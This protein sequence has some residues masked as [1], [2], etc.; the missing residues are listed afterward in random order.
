MQN[1]F[2]TVI[3]LLILLS[4]GL[5]AGNRKGQELSQK[6]ISRD[7]RLNSGAYHQIRGGLANSYLKFTRQKKGRVVFLGGSI[8]YGAGWRDDVCK[9]LQE[10]FPETKF[11]FINAGIGSTGST[12]GAFRMQ[13]DVLSFG[14]VDL[15]FEDASVNDR[16]N[17][18]DTAACVRG[19]EG[20]VHRALK[21]NPL[22]DIV[23][24]YFVDPSKIKDYNN[25]ITP[26]EIT[27]HNNVAVHYNLPSVNLAK[28]VTDRINNKE[29]TW[30]NDFL[31]LHP[32][33]FGHELY[34]N[35]IRSF[36]ETCWTQ[37][38]GKQKRE[39]HKIPSLLN[40]YSYIKA[41]Y[42]GIKG[43]VPDANWSFEQ[44]WT[45]DNS[46]VI[47]PMC[48][49]ISIVS[50][51]K[52]G[53]VIEFSFIG[54]AVGICAVTGPDAGMVEYTIDGKYK[55]EVDLY[56]PWSHGYNIPWFVVFKHDL[57]PS[58]HLLQVRVIDKRNPK[59]EGNAC[60]IIHFLVNK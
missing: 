26:V 39:P 4:Y 23:L 47:H 40:R 13:K 42:A 36:L 5:F 1:F 10:R 41:D 8:T 11:E 56:T 35:S 37:A 3:P 22:T 32:S 28:E 53:A 16:V 51:E 49:N 31:D 7:E 25:G 52:P 2:K 46:L 54:K 48:R 60:R 55:G 38:S 30:E 18:F 12:P 6:E 14:E 29:F 50:S 33:P 44:N 59:S 15:L 20:I 21:A 45:P 58:K 57:K 17:G 27:A 9:Y 34:F 19:M 24:L 43:A